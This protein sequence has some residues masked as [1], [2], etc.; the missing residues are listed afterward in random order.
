MSKFTLT[1]SIA[2]LASM[3]V[4]CQTSGLSHPPLTALF[5]DG[6]T[7]I[8]DGATPNTITIGIYNYNNPGTSRAESN[9]YT[10]QKGESILIRF[11]I[12]PGKGNEEPKRPWALT[13]SDWYSKVSVQAYFDENKAIDSRWDCSNEDNLLNATYRSYTLHAKEDILIKPGQYI[14]VVISGLVTKLP[15]GPTQAFIYYQPM[16]RDPLLS[17]LN[18]PFGNI[19]KSPLSIRDNKVGIATD[20]ANAAVFNVKGGARVQGGALKPGADNNIGYAFN[21]PG[22]GSTGISSRK[23]GQVGVYTNG[24]ETASFEEVLMAVNGEIWVKEPSKEQNYFVAQI[25]P[26][27]TYAL[28]T[29]VSHNIAAVGTNF[30]SLYKLQPD[31]VANSGFHFQFVPAGNGFYRIKNIGTGYNLTWDSQANGFRSIP[32]GD[33]DKSLFKPVTSGDG[34]FAFEIKGFPGSVLFQDWNLPP[35]PKE[36]RGYLFNIIDLQKYNQSQAPAYLK[37]GAKGDYQYKEAPTGIYRK[38]TLILDAA[39]NT[40]TGYYSGGNANMEID[41]ASGN[42]WLKGSLDHRGP[43]LGIAGR[44]HLF[45]DNN[46]NMVIK[47]GVTNATAMTLQPDGMVRFAKPLSVS[48]QATDGQWIPVPY[49]TTDDWNIFLSPLDMDASQEDGS[50]DDALLGFTCSSSRNSSGWNVYV[51]ARYSSGGGYTPKGYTM[52]RTFYD[53]NSQPI[54]VNYLLVR[55]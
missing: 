22:N 3:S 7:V 54:H 6:S 32:T 26:N 9:D 10:I 43:L 46:N 8:N 24:V 42:M 35:G 11:I 5:L 18:T 21:N 51:K 19:E 37:L 50:S 44:W 53:S 33:D 38:P 27:K 31:R 52:N 17:A 20:S 55:K 49:G 39:S 30:A 48:G 15:D 13:T 12:D 25:E 1:L 40:S 34:N 4:W 16:Q 45:V 14:K 29:S 47:D 36:N 23:D 2:L 41:N 28:V